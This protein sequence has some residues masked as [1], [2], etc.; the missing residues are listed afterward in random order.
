MTDGFG[1][2]DVY[3]V[4]GSAYCYPDSGVLRNKFGI[5]D[6][7]TLKS[8][9]TDIS[10]A[11]QMEMIAKPV[12]G[13]F[14][15]HHLCAIHRRLLGDVYPFAG[16]F[17]REDIAKGETRFLSFR[18]IKPRL[19]ALLSALHDEKYLSTL[20]FEGFLD[21]L[22]YYFAELNYI[23]PFREGNGRTIREFMRLLIER[24]GYQVNWGA[25]S[26]E[27]LLDAMVASVYDTEALKNVLRDCL[28]K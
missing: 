23:H 2:Y 17:R 19:S 26:A 5:Q 13:R 9:E 11:R 6:A 27:T 18:D 15:V 24:N 22:A 25:V 12:P 28:T 16:Q 3:S 20:T 10:A 7:G 8:V 14:T 21:R 1:K 4:A